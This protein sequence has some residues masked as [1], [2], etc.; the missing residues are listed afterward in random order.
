MDHESEEKRKA[1]QAG[2]PVRRHERANDSRLT[3]ALRA[4][5]S[6]RKAQARAQR[7]EDVPAADG[8]QGKDRR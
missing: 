5:L 7:E 3:A 6:R 2:R 4:N 8:E 1:A